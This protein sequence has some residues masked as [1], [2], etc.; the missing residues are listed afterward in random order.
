MGN[1]KSKTGGTQADVA[2]EKA[3]SYLMPG[4]IATRRDCLREFFC[5]T[6]D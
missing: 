2:K 6:Q 3:Y 1:A 4:L 5:G